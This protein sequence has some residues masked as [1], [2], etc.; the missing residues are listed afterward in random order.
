MVTHMRPVGARTDALARRAP[1]FRA[2]TLH[3]CI[4]ARDPTAAAAAAA[5][6]QTPQQK[7]ARTPKQQTSNP[8]LVSR[9][10]RQNHP[11]F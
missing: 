1:K 10:L 11:N 4:S 8:H 2:D 5:A 6:A 9:A 3:H 7:H